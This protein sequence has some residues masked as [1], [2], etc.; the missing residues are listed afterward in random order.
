MEKTEQEQEFSLS[1]GPMAAKNESWTFSALMR[2]SL[3]DAK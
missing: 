2:I 1:L 3:S